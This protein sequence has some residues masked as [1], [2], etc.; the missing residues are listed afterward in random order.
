VR[1][2]LAAGPARSGRFGA[3]H[4][5][6]RGAA[7]G[8]GAREAL[9]RYFRRFALLAAMLAGSQMA[10]AGSG[11]EPVSSAA[12]RA[13]DDFYAFVNEPWLQATAIPAG[14]TNF[15][16]VAALQAR[17]AQRIEALITGAAAGTLAPTESE[18]PGVRALVADYYAAL[19]DATAIER[20]GLQGLAEELAVIAAIHDGPTLAAALGR[21]LYLDD[22]SNTQTET[23]LGIWIHQD[24]HDPDRHAVHLLQGGLGLPDRDD[25]LDSAA[26]RQD[27]RE[28]YRHHLAT[29]FALAQ[30]ADGEQRAGRVLELEVAIARTHAS[31]ADT[32]D[33]FKT[34]NVWRR[35]DLLA[36]APGLDWPAFLRAARLDHVAAFVVWQPSAVVGAAALAQ[37][38]PLEAWK[39][40]LWV[41]VIEHY[42]PALPQVFAQEHQALRRGPADV[43]PAFDRAQAAI[44]ETDRA[45][46]PAVGQLYAQRYFPAASKAAATRMVENIRRAF[47]ARLA[48]IRWMDPATQRKALAK[49]DRVEVGVG[50]P[51]RWV[52]Y[53]GLPV[54]RHDPLANR[55]RVEDF[56]Y[57]RALAKLDEPVDPGEW[58]LT[59]QRVNAFINFSPNSLQF[60]AALLEE[61]F[62][63]ADGDA[64]ANYGSAGAGIS[65][66]IWHSFDELGR[67]YDDAGRL[68]DWWTAADQARFEAATAPLVRQYSGYCLHAGLCVSGERV[69]T[70]SVADLVGLVVAHDAYR[71]SL[72]GAAAPVKDGLTGEQRFFRAFAQRWRRLQSDD[73]LRLGLQTDTHAPPA[74]RAAVVRNLDAWYAAFGA[75]PGDR[76]YLAPGARV[77]LP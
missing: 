73:A 34:D 1:H 15:D 69:R 65:H 30:Q 46:G 43:A 72:G 13:G 32:D 35:E 48:A 9:G 64:A 6:D 75:K 29:L 31:R 25:Y 67:L 63:V 49:L 23:L 52:A 26:P 11:G 12:V 10:A 17:S 33:V 50:Y 7:T 18:A 21:R 3:R 19:T 56:E 38:L 76:L 28:R 60:A 4:P 66:E 27:L 47:R 14:R 45:L 54:S 61:P 39:D 51:E 5:G 58:I 37:R 8:G 24:F 22:G 62:F 77:R 41:R 36:R 55:R 2:R 42:A 71:L 74:Y 59:P 44:T 20:N 68:G 16:T 70:E 40:Y 53:R 57:Q